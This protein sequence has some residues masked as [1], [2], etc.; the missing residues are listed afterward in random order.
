MASKSP[1]ATIRASSLTITGTLTPLVGANASD[2]ADTTTG[3]VKLGAAGRVRVQLTYTRDGAS[4]TGRPKVRVM[5]SHDAPS[6]APASV[7]RWVPAML[8]ADA[9]SSAG[10]LDLA[11]EV[12]LLGPTAA[13]ASLFVTPPVDVETAHWMRV[14]LGDADGTHPGAV[15]AV[16]YGAVTT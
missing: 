6:T 15:S 2:N 5:I 8:A 1:A 4:S 16:V 3:A 14:D 10:V 7:G 11:P 12:M 13:G 9:A